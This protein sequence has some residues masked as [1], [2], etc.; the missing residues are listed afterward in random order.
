M[1]LGFNTVPTEYIGE[2]DLIL[3]KFNYSIYKGFSKDKNYKLKH[4]P[5]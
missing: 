2:F 3:N 1:K 5:R 4:E